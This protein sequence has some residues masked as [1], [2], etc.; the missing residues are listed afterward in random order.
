MAANENPGALAGATG[1]ERPIQATEEGFLKLTELR[2]QRQ[3]HEAG[4]DY[5]NVVANICNGSQAIGNVDYVQLILPRMD[6]LS[7]GRGP[8]TG[9]DSFLTLTA[10]IDGSQAVCTRIDPATLAALTAPPERFG[11]A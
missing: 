11:G 9:P 5:F 6:A 3:H 1:A 10:L 8:Q 4:D 7:A 2:A